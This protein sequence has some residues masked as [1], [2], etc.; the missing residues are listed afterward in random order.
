MAETEHTDVLIIGA[1]VI[2]MA[3]A[4]ELSSRGAKVTVIDRGEPGQGC[5][6]GNAGWITPCF[7]LPLPMPG[8]FWKSLKWLSNPDSPLY[9][10]PEP[11]LLLARWLW[12][13]MRSMNSKL[14]LES[15]AALTE[16][17]KYSIEAYARLDQAFPDSLGFERKGLLMVGET[18]AG[19]RA[20]IEEMELV[21]R[22]GIPGKLLDDSGVKELEPALRGSS[23]AGFTFPKKPMPSP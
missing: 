3:T 16:I 23:K 18:D 19:V 22:H 1:G 8:M 14:M 6:Y 2:G 12:R 4:Y 13:F 7:A 20:A 17:S 5:S 11:S 21:G 10:K 15:V 9:I